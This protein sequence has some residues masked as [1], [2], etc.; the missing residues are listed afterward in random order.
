MEQLLEQAMPALSITE[1]AW[2]DGHLLKALLNIPQGGMI[3]VT[4]AILF[5]EPQHLAAYWWRDPQSGEDFVNFVDEKRLR[6]AV[7][8]LSWDSGY[9]P[10]GTLRLGLSPTGAQWALIY[11]SSRQYQLTFEV[12]ASQGM[13][14]I[15]IKMP[16][17]VF[18]G[19]GEHYYLWAVKKG[20]V[21]G[22][23]PLYQ[24]PLPN[25]S[26]EGALCFGE[27]TP[28]RA[29][30]AGMHPAL[31]LFLDSPFIGHWAQG[32]S[33]VHDGDIRERLL[34]LAEAS[35]ACFPDNELVPIISPSSYRQ[36]PEPISLDVHLSH[37]VRAY[38]RGL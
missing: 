24:Y 18:F 29:A 14:T 34:A 2:Q 27:N 22:K 38:E 35:P 15:R 7:D 11:Q 5:S 33:T 36:H 37:V 21:S 30:W 19:I 17:G 32:K 8:R 26:E 25:I 6:L 16:A 9:V 28:P 10:A 12:P 20:T 3:G 13:T 4:A 23:T 1:S 31:S